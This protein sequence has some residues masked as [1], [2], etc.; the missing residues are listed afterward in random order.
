MEA[1]FGPRWLAPSSTPIPSCF[2]GLPG[3]SEESEPYQS[4][5]SYSN[6]CN[7]Y[8]VPTMYTLQRC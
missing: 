8:C 7:I 5:Q 3:P 2:Q 4:P 6:P 1:G